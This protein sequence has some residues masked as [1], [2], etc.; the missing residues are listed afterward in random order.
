MHFWRSIH[1]FTSEN[2][3]GTY[4]CGW[5]ISWSWSKRWKSDLTWPQIGRNKTNRTLYNINGLRKVVFSQPL[6]TQQWFLSDYNTVRCFLSHRGKCNIDS[7]TNMR[8]HQCSFYS[9][10]L[11]SLSSITVSVSAAA[12]TYTAVSPSLWN[13][14]VFLLICFVFCVY[15]N[16]FWWVCALGIRALQFLSGTVE[17]RAAVSAVFLQFTR[18]ARAALCF[19]AFARLHNTAV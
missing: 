2:A 7:L 8:L 19:C 9:R 5:F 10:L 13:F 4:S 11:C 3:Y 1:V 17:L 15:V 18:R 12:H 14:L 6:D 16:A